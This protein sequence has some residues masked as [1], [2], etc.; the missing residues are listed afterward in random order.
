M[1]HVYFRMS[2]DWWTI[3]LTLGTMVPIFPTDPCPSLIAA[4]HPFC[5]NFSQAVKG[6]HKQ[7]NKHFVAATVA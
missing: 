5:L 4:D 6:T 2:V 7:T 1:C 3:T